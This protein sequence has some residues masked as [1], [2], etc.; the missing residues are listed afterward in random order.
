MLHSVFVIIFVFQTLSHLI[1]FQK[2]KKKKRGRNW[3]IA[4]DT[5]I[6]VIRA[7]RN[8]CD[9]QKLK[10]IKYPYLFYK[11]LLVTCL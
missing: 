6:A 1:F 11:T 5:L 7:Q 2:K 9:I 4:T 8:K 10:I 3:L